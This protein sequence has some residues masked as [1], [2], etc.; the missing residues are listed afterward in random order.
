[1]SYFIR[2][3]KINFQA[4]NKSWIAQAVENEANIK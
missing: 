1:M 2:A 4:V 3:R